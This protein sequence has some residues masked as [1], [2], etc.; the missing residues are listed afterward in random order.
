MRAVVQRV[1]RGEVRVG[2]KVVGQIGKGLL[3]YLGV[4]ETDTPQDID[5][6]VNKILNLRIMEDQNG[7][8]NLSL[9]DLGYEIL[10]VSQFT[11]CA[12]ARKGRRPSYNDAAN[13]EKALEYYDKVA[14][15]AR[16]NGVRVETGQFQSMMEV[17]YINW[18]PVTILLDSQKKF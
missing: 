11:L 14:E 3:V 4:M 5:Y 15:S 10:L 7:K 17:D 12:D 13:P 18:G 16:S 2:D 6:M 9:L 8:M 1:T